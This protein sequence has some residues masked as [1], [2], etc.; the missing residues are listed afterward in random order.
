MS[1][2]DADTDLTGLFGSL[3]SSSSRYRYAH[4][5]LATPRRE[6]HAVTLLADHVFNSVDSACRIML[7]ALTRVQAF[8]L[9]EAIEVGEVACPGGSGRL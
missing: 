7:A 9:A 5:H 1:D 3:P 2:D 6:G 8:A 4:L